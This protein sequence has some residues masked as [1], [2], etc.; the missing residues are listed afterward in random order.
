[1]IRPE[2]RAEGKDIKPFSW[3]ET[4]LLLVFSWFRNLF[5]EPASLSLHET[6]PGKDTFKSSLIKMTTNETTN[7]LWLPKYSQSTLLAPSTLDRT[8]GRYKDSLSHQPFTNNLMN[9]SKSICSA[10]TP[11]LPTPFVLERQRMH[12]QE[13]SWGTSVSYRLPASLPSH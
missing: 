6:G 1:M 9:W 8:C 2:S 13:H 3:G 11:P 5:I 10:Q 4:I 12:L 7:S